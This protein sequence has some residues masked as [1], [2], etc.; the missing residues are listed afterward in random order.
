[1]ASIL[2]LWLAA[3]L[4]HAWHERSTSTANWHPGI[5]HNCQ[6]HWRRRGLYSTSYMPP[7]WSQWEIWQRPSRDRGWCCHRWRWWTTSLKSCACLTELDVLVG[8]RG[9]TKTEWLDVI[10]W[11][12][13]MWQGLSHVGS[14]WYMLDKE[15]A[16]VDASRPSMQW[17]PDL[18][19][20]CC[21]MSVDLQLYSEEYS[22]YLYQSSLFISISVHSYISYII[23]LNLFQF[24]C[25]VNDNV[26]M[27]ERLKQDQICIKETDK[28]AYTSC[29]LWSPPLRKLRQIYCD[30]GICQSQET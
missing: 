11:D 18:L 3:V 27:R 9:S 10:W 26:R 6:V 17:W 1:M 22:I 7:H 25:I 4:V 15:A 20:C 8:H 19:V 23:S 24:L 30:V 5:Y 16:T 13:E 21:G 2:W 12:T 28:N 14:R 29:V